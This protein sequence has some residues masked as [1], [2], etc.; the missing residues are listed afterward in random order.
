MYRLSDSDFLSNAFYIISNRSADIEQKIER[1]KEAKRDIEVEQDQAFIE[2][3][4]IEKPSLDL[5]WEGTEANKF[6]E[7]R[8]EAYQVMKTKISNYDHYIY[9]IDWEISQLKLQQNTLDIASSIAYQADRLLDQGEEA[10]EAF[11]RKINELKG[12]LF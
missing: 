3:K 12:W 9:R 1:L 10:V 8:R 11:G 2:I 5:S 6:D 7:D 4:Q